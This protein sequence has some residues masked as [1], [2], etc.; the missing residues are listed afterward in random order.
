VTY[1]IIGVETANQTDLD[2]IPLNF[3]IWGEIP[4]TVVDTFY[5]VVANLLNG[6]S[7]GTTPEPPDRR[8]QDLPGTTSAG[9]D[10]SSE[11]MKWYWILLI[12][13]GGAVGVTSMVLA[14][15]FGVNASKKSTDQAKTV[16]LPQETSEPGQPN[17]ETGGCIGFLQPHGGKYTK[18]IQVPIACARPP[19]EP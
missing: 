15:Y 6:V 14:I 9:G 7:P 16:L 17:P 2:K 19:Q 10:S 11:P 4:V 18:V 3:T 13:L 8:A 1:T 5:N 12:A